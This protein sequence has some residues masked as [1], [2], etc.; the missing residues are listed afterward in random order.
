MDTETK[1]K[2]VEDN[3]EEEILS[4]DTKKV[5]PETPKHDVSVDV[6]DFISKA[7]DSLA[8]NKDDETEEVELE[9]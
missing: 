1:D 3:F 6:E 4:P 8:F 7:D 5:T 2:S 9:W